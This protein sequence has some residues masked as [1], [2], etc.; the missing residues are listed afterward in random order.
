M[1]EAFP[2]HWPQGWPR[3]DRYK[4]ER[5]RFDVTPDRARREMLDEIRLLGGREVIISTD[6]PLRL[7]GQPY[8]NR[9]TP[10]DPGCAVYFKRKGSD[11][12][13]ACDKYDRLHDNMRA[14]GKTI[15]AL[16]G[17]DRW[18]ASDMLDRAFTGFTA[19][20]APEQW[21]QVLEVASDASE[22]EIQSAYRQKARTAHPDVGGSEAAMARLN[23]ARDRGMMLQ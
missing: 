10:D 16:R 20:P 2:L 19:L 18:G 15:G 8:A 14:I 21:F 6:T 3:T 1:T 5:A 22:A 7:D 11:A 23:D 17:I 12:V 9:R 4:R 13:F